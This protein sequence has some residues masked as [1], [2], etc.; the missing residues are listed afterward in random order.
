L[1]EP[2]E[3]KR[4][5]AAIFAADV[6]GYSRL[7]GADE[8]AT[9]DALT[10][11]REILD[12]LIAT[13]GGR[14]ANTAGDSVLAE[15]GSAVDAVRCAMEAQDALAKANS[16]LPETRHINFRIGVH[17]GDV[18]VRAGD[19][20]GDGVNIAARLQTLARAGG[21]CVSGVT[22]D[23]VRK[24]LPLSFTDL[25]AQTVK[26]IEEPIRAYEAWPQGEAAP[27]VAK[28]ISPHL[29][30][31][32]LALPDRPSIAVLPFQNMSGDPEQEYFADGVVED[33]ITALCRFKSLFVIAR[34]SS[35]TYK[36][37]AVDIKQ[38]GRELGVRY[39]LEGSVRKA[40][41]R[42]RITGQL[43]D[44]TTGAHLW[45]DRFD[46]ALE[47]IFD[48]QDK[49]TQQVIG[50]IAPEIDRAEIERA[51]R[52][53][54]GNVDAVTEYYRGVPHSQWPTSPENNDAALR[55]FK[56]AIA[57]DPTYSP[58]YG[59]AATCLMWRRANKWPRDNAED[60]A[61]LL[62]LAERVKELNTDD[63]FALVGLGF[64]LVVNNVDRDYEVGL[65]MMD[66]AIRSNP[67]YGSAYFS[68]G[69]LRVWDGGSDT[70]IADFEQ[71][72]R[73]SPR[74]PF[75]YASMIGMAFGHYNAAR[76]AEAANWADK[77]IRAF[78]PYFIPGL[79][80]AIMVYVGAG[81][82]EDAQR[83]MADGLRM[84][85][86]WRRSTIPEWNGLR[87]PELRMKFREAFL[88]AGLPE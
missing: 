82:V 15:F 83:M 65:D 78:P 6:E 73:F 72:M 24:I 76:Y 43:I 29:D 81:R 57:L 45:A 21:L 22:Y 68:R 86:D 4:R 31:K 30:P 67:N 35:F 5:L 55:H 34:N 71:S 85:P 62:R 8:V 77:A 44:V 58:A 18:M 2:I 50:A 20:F 36:G 84:V 41:G 79:A 60:D 47:D 12:G 88:K 56:N 17:V 11:R 40:G 27:S 66:R 64:A 7:M 3:T 49:L 9:L 70:A 48:L 25:G 74:D 54:I 1:A 32:P 80:I 26:N 53:P 87:S 16:P 51:S 63:A 33:I 19:L 39:V 13:H 38:V 28:D 69:F 23:Q 42:L 10:A 37:K 46:G 59:G 52:R 75:S 61:Q 14:I